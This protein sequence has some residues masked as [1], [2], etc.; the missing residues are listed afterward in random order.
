MEKKKK[1]R[2]GGGG[3]EGGGERRKIKEGER[4]GLSAVG[5]RVTSP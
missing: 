4:A 2:G 3:G 5:F 1:K